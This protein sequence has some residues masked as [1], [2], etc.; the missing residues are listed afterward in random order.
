[1]NGM[2]RP[3]WVLL[4]QLKHIRTNFTLISLTI[5]LAVA[6]T[7]CVVDLAYAQSSPPIDAASTQ[8]P[9]SPPSAAVSLP[10]ERAEAQTTNQANRQAALTE[11]AQTRITNL[12]ANISNRMEA[13]IARLQTISARLASRVEKMAAEGTDT[14]TAES[15]ITEANALLER[16]ATRLA[17]IDTSIA[18]V[19]GSPSPASAWQTA[20]RT[21]TETRQDLASARTALARAI[22]VLRGE[23]PVIETDE[24]APG[25]TTESEA[26]EPNTDPEA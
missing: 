6:A 7:A 16:A 24:A 23:T 13:I 2:E 19:V 14:A 26:G 4:Q 17:D 9:V 20:R 12:A 3:R 15:Y 8:A 21:Y 18:A 1:M 25:T 5:L 11:R 10:P 22:A